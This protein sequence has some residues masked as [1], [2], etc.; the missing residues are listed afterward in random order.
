MPGNFLV[1]DSVNLL[2][3]SSG[4]M[5]FLSADLDLLSHNSREKKN[6]EDKS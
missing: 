4:E 3:V 1:I 6:P 5:K 2:K